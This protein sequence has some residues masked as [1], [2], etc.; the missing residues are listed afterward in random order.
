MSKPFKMRSGNS[1]MFKL[2]GASPVKQSTDI[3]LTNDEQIS[4]Y[5]GE[6]KQDIKRQK[7]EDLAR[8]H[9][10]QEYATGSRSGKKT[11]INL[12]PL[13]IINPYGALSGQ[14]GHFGITTSQVRKVTDPK[15]RRQWKKQLKKKHKEI[16]SN[17]KD[18]TKLDIQARKEREN[19]VKNIINN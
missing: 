2:M 6:T 5:L 15:Q 1:P 13:S 9:R 11:N 7:K 16:R 18:Q 10:Q 3:I 12:N 17:I 19:V 4:D 14:G 8:S